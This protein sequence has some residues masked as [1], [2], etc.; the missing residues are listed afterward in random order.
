MARFIAPYTIERTTGNLTFYCWE[1]ENFARKKSSL[2]RKKVLQSPRFAST[3]YYAGLMAR[4]S[5]I[6]SFVYDGLPAYWRQGW[7]FRSFTGEALTLLK[8]GKTEADI[9]QL[10]YE[11]YVKE[12]A[13]KQRD[14]QQPLV[15]VETKIKRAYRKR[16]TAYWNNKTAKRQQRALRKQQLQHHAGL[17]AQA[18]SIASKLYRQLPLHERTRSCFQQLTGMAMR[19]LKEGEA[20]QEITMAR[21]PPTLA[22]NRSVIYIGDE[23]R[24][25]Y[26]TAPVHRGLPGKPLTPVPIKWVREVAVYRMCERGHKNGL[27]SYSNVGC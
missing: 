8:E 19:A 18:S 16:D 7:M 6:G 15:V 26:F 1:G 23:K 3:R 4:A 24:P 27:Y 10:L 9:Q 21:K 2:T 17:L 5:A 12:V 20:E 11:R 13:D 14:S 22:K 25:V